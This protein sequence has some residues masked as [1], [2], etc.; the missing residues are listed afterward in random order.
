MALLSILAFLASIGFFGFL[1]CLIFLLRWFVCLFF[2][3]FGCIDFIGISDILG[4]LSKNF[5]KTRAT[6]VFARAKLAN[7]GLKNVPVW[8]EE[9]AINILKNMVQSNTTVSSIFLFDKNGPVKKTRASYLIFRL[10]KL[11]FSV[12]SPHEW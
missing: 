6:I 4:N 11:I 7:N 3:F 1:A 5:S 12:N 8:E 2:G 9:F 10:K